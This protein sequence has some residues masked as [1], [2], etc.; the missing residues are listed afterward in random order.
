MMSDVEGVWRIQQH[1]EEV[2]HILVEDKGVLVHCNRRNSVGDMD[3]MAGEAPVSVPVSMLYRGCPCFIE[4][5]GAVFPEG[6]L[7]SHFGRH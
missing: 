6:I 3:N 2:A 4:G 1:G 7:G 5:F